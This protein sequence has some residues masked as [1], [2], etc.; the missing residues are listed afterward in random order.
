M[1]AF[2]GVLLTICLSI[3]SPFG[4]PQLTLSHIID[5]E[6]KNKFLFSTHLYQKKSTLLLFMFSAVNKFCNRH[7][8]KLAILVLLLEAVLN[9]LIIQRVPY[10]EIDWKAYMQE[11]D[12]FLNG[13]WNYDYL[14]GETGPC[15][16][17]GGFIYIFSVFSMITDKGNDIRLAQYLFEFTY[18]LFIGIVFVIYHKAR[19]SDD[20]KQ[21]DRGS[22]SKPIVSPL[23]T[24]ILLC[25][26]RRI[27]S[28]FVLR[29][30]NDCIVMLFA[31]MSIIALIHDHWSIG[32]IL[33]RH[34]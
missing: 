19:V 3:H 7:F 2:C 6:L 17:P 23:F 4:C 9:Y 18:L 26:S 27:H 25:M 33:L 8:F 21:K 22:S 20:L 16:Y 31:Y 11:V 14:R 13:E 28:I 30:F 29:L 10:T 32:S 15:V 24:L 34:V 12:G 5:V 1:S